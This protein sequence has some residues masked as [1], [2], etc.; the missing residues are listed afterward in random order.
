MRIQILILGFKGGR[1]GTLQSILN[2]KAYNNINTLFLEDL[3]V[4]YRFCELFST[5]LFYI[6]VKSSSLSRSSGIKFY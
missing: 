6:E 4:F 2:L 1:K 3:N 5:I